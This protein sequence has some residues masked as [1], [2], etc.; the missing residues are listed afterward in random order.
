MNEKTIT[1]AA[2]K[3]AVDLPGI[4]VP[5]TV[6]RPDFAT[7]LGLIFSFGLIIGAIAIGQSDAKFFNVPSVLIVVLGTITATSISFTGSELAR[8]VKIIATS[9]FRPVVNFSHL[10]ESLVGLATIAR[11]KGLLFLSSYEN[12]TSKEAFLEH[13]MA[14]VIDGYS[15]NDVQR[16]LQHNID[17]GEERKKRA[18][19]I[20]RR[21]SEVAPAM[22]LIGTLV[23]LVQMLANLE[24]PETIGPAMA[25]ALLTTFYGAILGTIVMSPLAGKIEKNADDEVTAKSMV[26]K[27]ALSMIAQENPRNLEM[28]INTMLPPSQRIQYFD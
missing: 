13:A 17:L 1:D 23:G 11:K 28:L 21:A 2:G 22:G 15:A 6:H 9:I 26:L 16:I 10:A 14:I 12:E 5:S 19:S 20:L 8:S 18:A 27:T 4:F 25:V 7:I 3:N 24:N